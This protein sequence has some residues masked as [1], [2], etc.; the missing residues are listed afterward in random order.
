MASQFGESPQETKRKLM[1][2]LEVMYKLANGED[3]ITAD[4]E[5]GNT[6]FAEF[7]PVLTLPPSFKPLLYL[8]SK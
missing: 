4:T 5:I 3:G 6:K 8:L 2:W 7:C 1:V